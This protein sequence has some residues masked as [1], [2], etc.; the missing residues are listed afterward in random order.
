MTQHN[1]IF[2]MAGGIG[3][4]FWP[5]SRNTY[6]KQFIDIL[7]VGKSLLQL[8]YERFLK[9]CPAENIFVVTNTTYKDLIIIQL[10]DISSGNILCEPSRNNTAPC[11]AY[12]AFKILAKDP[13]ACM[14][15]APSDHFILHEDIFVRDI[16]RALEI[17]TVENILL[18]L[19]ISPT[20]PD[21]GYGYIKFDKIDGNGA[22]KVIQ[23]T[24][25]PVLEKAMEFVNS[26]DYVWNAGI[27]IWQ[28]NAILSAFETLSP[29]IYTLFKQ[30]EAVYNTKDEQVFVDGY[31]PESPNISIDY[32]IMEKAD[33]VYTIP[34]DFGWSDLGTWASLHQVADKNAGNKNVVAGGE[35]QL[36]DT[37]DCIIHL[38]KDKLA[39]I[40]GL[41]DFIVV[42]DENVLLIYPKSAEQEIKKITEQ[43]KLQEK[44]GYL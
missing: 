19:G 7:G 28:A 6:P 27:F 23:F 5:K 37:E 10:P 40:R 13:E 41:K 34:V 24:E 21:T 16:K 22:H 9:V 43:L 42:D 29:E 3:S 44:S 20:R 36:E 25:K 26:G 12:A 33:N 17:V 11:I 31:Y 15:I 8:T 4:R 18:T 39:V 1:Y 30:G 35:S 2:I 32:A 38:P 14:V